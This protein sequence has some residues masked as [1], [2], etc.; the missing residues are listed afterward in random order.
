MA[1]HPTLDVLMSG[2]RDATCRV[3]DMRTKQQIFAFT[4]HKNTVTSIVAQD[5]DPQVITGSSDST[6][7]LWDLAAGKSITTLTHHKKSVRSLAIHPK[8]FTFVSGSTNSIKQWKFPEGNFLQN[9][10]GHNSIINTLCVNQ[11]SV[12]FS[13]G[14]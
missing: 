3:W 1:L 6:I 10:E 12:L 2:G 11:D 13:G 5:A 14:R 8:E 7:R 4:G 9:L